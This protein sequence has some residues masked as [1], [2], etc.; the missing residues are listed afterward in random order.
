VLEYDNGKREEISVQQ[1]HDSMHEYGGLATLFSN[2]ES[3]L[4]TISLAEYR[5]LSR[6]FISAWQLFKEELKDARDRDKGH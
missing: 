6:P 5:Q 4:V 3:G 1:I 2:I